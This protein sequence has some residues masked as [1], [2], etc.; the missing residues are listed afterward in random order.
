MTKYFV[1]GSDKLETAT[2]PSGGG[3]AVPMLTPVTPV[4]A[5][6]TEDYPSVGMISA[7]DGSTIAISLS[8]NII[9]W[10]H[11]FTKAL[12]A[13]SQWKARLGFTFMPGSVPDAV[14]PAIMGLDYPNFGLCLG[15]SASPDMHWV[16]LTVAAAGSYSLGW[17]S[18]FHF[19]R[20]TG[21]TTKNSTTDFGSGR[22]CPLTHHW[23]QFYYDG[24]YWVYFQISINGLDWITQM[25][26]HP[27]FT[28]TKYG[29]MCMTYG[30]SSQQVR[31]F[32]LD[33]INVP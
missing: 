24:S 22:L 14:Y 2:T 27:D 29:F 16:G 17:G 13:Y 8:E 31:V 32:H 5:D 26:W 10:H 18:Y 1:L 23:I 21:A 25:K 12:P 7:Q 20:W 6:L 4:L 11:N 19:S 33:C 30:N 15:D 9:W 28:I 3:G